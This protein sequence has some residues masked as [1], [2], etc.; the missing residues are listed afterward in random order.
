VKGK[1]VT[2][3]TNTEGSRTVDVV[4]YLLQDELALGGIYSSNT[5]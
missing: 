1:K 4:P 2:G 3:F 5:D